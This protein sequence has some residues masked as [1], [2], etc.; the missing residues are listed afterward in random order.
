[1]V[2]RVAG[3][4]ES[5]TRVAGEHLPRRSQAC[6]LAEYPTFLDGDLFITVGH[7]VVAETACLSL[8]AVAHSLERA[9]LGRLFWRGPRDLA[10]AGAELLDVRRG[11]ASERIERLRKKHR[12]RIEKTSLD[13][14]RGAA[15]NA[16]CA[17]SG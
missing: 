13:A 10:R 15:H 1:M 14:R 9:Y 4:V 12:N 2:P 16:R 8:L 17:P 11:A 5:S 7:G 3:S 6:R